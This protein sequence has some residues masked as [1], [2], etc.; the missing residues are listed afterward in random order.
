MR[1]W[2]ATPSMVVR[3]YLI[4]IHSKLAL[5]VIKPIPKRGDGAANVLHLASLTLELVDNQLGVAIYWAFPKVKGPTA[6]FVMESIT[7]SQKFTYLAV[8]T[9]A[10]LTPVVRIREH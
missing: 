6:V 10:A 4:L 7:V 1:L 3:L 8:A 5:I 9:I 2:D